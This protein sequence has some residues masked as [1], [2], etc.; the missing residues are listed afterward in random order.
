M[1]AG[2]ADSSCKLSAADIVWILNY[3]FLGGPPPKRGCACSKSQT[4]RR[5][6]NEDVEL[7]ENPNLKP[8]LER[9]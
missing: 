6:D 9:R 1:E 8:L 3:L 7:F 4:G 5:T 2:D